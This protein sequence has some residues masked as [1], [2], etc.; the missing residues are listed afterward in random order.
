MTNIPFRSSIVVAEEKPAEFRADY[1]RNS[2][3]SIVSPRRLV[4]EG[5]T[6]D[7]I[8]KFFSTPII[9][10]GLAIREP[11]PVTRSRY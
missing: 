4:D 8:R 1:A 3:R 10:F 6:S 9:T 5:Q 7:R 11:K 2:R